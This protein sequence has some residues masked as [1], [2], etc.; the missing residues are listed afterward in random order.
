[1][2][3]ETDGGEARETRGAAR[4]LTPVLAGLALALLVWSGWQAW[5]RVATERRLDALVAGGEQIFAA[6]DAYV[7]DR[8]APPPPGSSRPGGLNARTL[9]P[10][11]SEGYLAGASGIIEHLAG[12]RI[13]AYDV[14]G[15]R[16]WMVIRDADDPRL[17]LLIARTD[18]FPLV[19]ET[20]IEGLYRIEGSRLVKIEPPPAAPRRAGRKDADGRS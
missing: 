10:L 7:A 4:W 2:R 6:I 16:F 19:P 14:A 11:S 15:E 1:M 17:A 5:Q 13:S 20:W 12:Q 18:R 3:D 8:G 9:A